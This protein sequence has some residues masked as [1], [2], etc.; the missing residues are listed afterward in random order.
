MFFNPDPRL[1]G[2]Q[3]GCAEPDCQHRRKEAN[4]RQWLL[5]NPDYFE[6]RYPKIKSWLD[7]HPGYMTEYRRKHPEKV[8]SDN[9]ARKRRHLRVKA[10]RADIQVAKI[11]QEPVEKILT[12]VLSASPRADI[13]NSFLGQVIVT[14]LF[15][16]AYLQRA[17]AGIQGPIASQ[18]PADYDSK[19]E[20]NQ[21]S[22][23]P[24]SS[25]LDS[26]VL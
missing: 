15:S 8:Q 7:S 2:R 17:R 11:L 1:K 3:Y 23:P 14:S 13:Q 10:D 4:Q 26:Q 9:S 18:P 24:G 12:P 20:T 22:T 6:G 5:R 21:I 19:H 25:P 16:A